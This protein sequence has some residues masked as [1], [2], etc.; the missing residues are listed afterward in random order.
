VV[1]SSGVTMD[2]NNQE[3]VTPFTLFHGV[4]AISIIVCEVVFI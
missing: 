1:Y 4:F 3:T 2:R